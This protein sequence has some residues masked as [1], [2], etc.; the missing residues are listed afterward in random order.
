MSPRCYYIPRTLLLFLH[1]TPD[2]MHIKRS[3]RMSLG[4]TLF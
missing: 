3:F 2:C 4:R 1:F